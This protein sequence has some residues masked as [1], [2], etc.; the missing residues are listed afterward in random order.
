MNILNLKLK[1][2]TVGIEILVSSMLI[3]ISTIVLAL[4]LIPF[5]I[6][7]EVST[8]ALIPYIILTFFALTI[9]GLGIYIG[10]RYIKNKGFK[11]NKTF[12]TLLV[13][14]GL[15]Y[16]LYS[17]ASYIFSNITGN[18]GGELQPITAIFWAIMTIPLGLTLRN[19][20]R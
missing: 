13:V 16:F 20:C 5:S 11:R 14:L 2:K 7:S 4:V 15:G 1:S 18:I 3:L 17:I 6:A 12:G 19:G 9:S 10:I 8:L